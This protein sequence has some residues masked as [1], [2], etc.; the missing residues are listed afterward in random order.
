MAALVDLVV[1]WY[2]GTQLRKS[3]CPQLRSPAQ[4]LGLALVCRDFDILAQAYSRSFGDWYLQSSLL[5]ANTYELH[6]EQFAAGLPTEVDRL[7]KFLQLPWHDAMLNPATHARAKIFISTPS[8]AQVV[9]PVST[10]SVG[11]WKHKQQHFTAQVLAQLKL[12]IARWGYSL[13]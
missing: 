2:G 7:S 1:S 4:A 6:C 9:E 10:R 12:W 13:T 11:R 5:G 3:G 8:Y